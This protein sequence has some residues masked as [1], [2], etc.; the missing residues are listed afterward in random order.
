MWRKHFKF[1][2]IPAQSSH[3]KCDVC[4]SLMTL[5]YS[6][7]TPLHQRNQISLM[8]RAHRDHVVKERT[9]YWLRK[10]LAAAEPEMFLSFIM[11]GMDQSATALPNYH[12][13]LRKLLPIMK[14]HVFAVLNHC[15]QKPHFFLC[16]DMIRKDSNLSIAALLWSLVSVP[17]PWPPVLFIQVW[18]PGMYWVHLMLISFNAGG[19]LLARKQEPVDV[20]P[21]CMDC[22][23][24]L[25]S[26]DTNVISVEGSYT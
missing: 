17:Q 14:F 2:L 3:A 9:L 20:C 13:R 16:H 18:G 11:D 19:Q 15:S 12:P 10:D 4:T 7:S 26:R 25:G 21:L 22:Q 23:K 1:V 24:T 6:A 8:L 5:K